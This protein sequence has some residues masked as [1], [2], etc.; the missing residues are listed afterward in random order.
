M[1]HI[2]WHFGKQVCIYA[3]NDKEVIA[4]KQDK[5]WQRH[6]PPPPQEALMCLCFSYAVGFVAQRR[7]VLNKEL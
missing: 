3:G 5:D 6:N 1:T 4:P 2:V 7:Q